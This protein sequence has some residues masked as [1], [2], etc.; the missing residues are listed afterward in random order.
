MKTIFMD[1]ARQAGRLMM[2]HFR[3]IQDGQIE[4]K[5]GRKDL[6]TF[7]DK[8]VE[9]L[10]FD[11]LSKEF[12][13]HAL[14]GEEGGRVR[15]GSGA[16]LIVDPVD[17]T[18]NYAHGLPHFGISIARVDKGNVSHGLI[19]LPVFDEMYY[20]E[21]GL[22][23]FMNDQPIR[24][25]DRKVLGES[26]VATGF[27]CIRAGAKP[28]GMPVFNQLIY[29][30]RDLRRLGAATADLAYTARGLFEGFYEME[31]SPWDVCAGALLVTEA[32]GKVSGFLDEDNPLSGRKILASNGLIHD[33]LKTIIEEALTDEGLSAAKHS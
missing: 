22:G 4:E 13:D 23:A 17:G 15:G 2:R 19:Y 29:K 26:L 28:D 14:L 27:A 25:S 8:E 33:E 7:V 12:P 16:E 10:V 18:N 5:T 1:V 6:V 20:A 30:A 24:V 11:R 21:A 9:K 3:K 31:L 32:G